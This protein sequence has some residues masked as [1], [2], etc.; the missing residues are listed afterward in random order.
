MVPV[1]ALLGAQ[2]MNVIEVEIPWIKTCKMQKMLKTSR[3]KLVQL[4]IWLSDGTY[5]T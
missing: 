4:K 2:K 1:D 5:L 3:K